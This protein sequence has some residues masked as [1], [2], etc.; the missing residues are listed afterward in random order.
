MLH[1][2][3]RVNL[4]WVVS[5]IMHTYSPITQKCLN[6][7]LQ[8]LCH[9]NQHFQKPTCVEY[10]ADF[11]HFSLVKMEFIFFHSNFISNHGNIMEFWECKKLGTLLIYLDSRGN[12]R[13]VRN[14]SYI[15]IAFPI[16]WPYL[17][18]KTHKVVF[19]QE[20]LLK[21]TWKFVH[22]AVWMC[23][24]QW[25]WL[26]VCLT[27]SLL[28]KVCISLYNGNFAKKSLQFGVSL[29]PPFTLPFALPRWCLI[30]YSNKTKSI[31]DLH[32]RKK[33]NW[34]RNMEHFAAIFFRYSLLSN[35]A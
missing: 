22:L 21:I 35:V 31:L 4:W 27:S 25:W 10:Q 34:W 24:S 19:D 18:Q 13:D 20:E 11:D 26:E 2:I 8:N 1:N 14:I 30:S 28:D 23:L 16:W 9:W 12:D 32:I 3:P 17:F 29:I 15:S 6:V 33:S 5:K 7:Q